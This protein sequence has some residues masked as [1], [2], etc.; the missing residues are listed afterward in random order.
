MRAA[1]Y[2]RVSTDGQTA[3]NQR[4]A[5]VEVAAHRGWKVVE[6]YVDQGI[7][8]AK[9]RDKR[10]AFD[11]M[12]KDATRRKFDVVMAWAI[13]RIGRSVHD[14]S[15]FMVE[16]DLLGVKQYYHK[17]AI[18][19]ATPAGKAM[20]HM[21]VVFS[22]FERDMI[23]DRVNQGLQRAR[24]QGKRLGRPPIDPKT[25]QAICAALAKGEQGMLKIAARFKVGSGTVQ[26][27]KA[28]MAGSAI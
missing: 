23:R 4:M 1:I 8:G 14:V 10:P 5:L 16:M 27:I 18:D 21:C 25:E 11:K 24:A 22:E 28:G 26:R 19:T 12:C 9:G 3:E 7:S 20:I 13:D 2:C 15:G 17:Q 6:L